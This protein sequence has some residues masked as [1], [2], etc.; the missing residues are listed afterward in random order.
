M[1]RFTYI[2]QMATPTARPAEPP[3][4]PRC[5]FCVEGFRLVGD[6]HETRI[7]R[8]PC[9]GVKSITTKERE[10]QRTEVRW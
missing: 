8:I 5:A 2:P 7:G 4:D 1:K 3:Q 9:A 10:W 6:E